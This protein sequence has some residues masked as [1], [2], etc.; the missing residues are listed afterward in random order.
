MSQSAECGVVV[1]QWYAGL[2]NHDRVCIVA[3]RMCFYLRLEMQ[4][5]RVA[6]KLYVMWGTILKGLNIS[7]RKQISTQSSITQWT[8]PYINNTHS[9]DRPTHHRSSL[10]MWEFWWISQLTLSPP[11]FYDVGAGKHGLEFN[12][13]SPA[14]EITTCKVP[15]RVFQ[16][17]RW[18]LCS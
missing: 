7:F 15:P 14:P 12:N 18:V 6:D 11:T 17:W 10:N 1:R 4:W 3:A 9:E 2:R 5:K 13:R 16:K 8:Q